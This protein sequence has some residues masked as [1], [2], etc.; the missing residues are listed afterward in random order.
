[1]SLQRSRLA[2]F[3]RRFWARGNRNDFE[4]VVVL[5]AS[6]AADHYARAYC[7]EG[8][9]TAQQLS[10]AEALQKKQ[11][12]RLDRVLLELGYV[13]ENELLRALGE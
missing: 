11:G 4:R 1:M 6:C 2:R 10:E 12:S 9:I 8:V 3:R 13:E 5:P 7:R